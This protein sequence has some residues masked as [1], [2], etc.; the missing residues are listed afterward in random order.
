MR[1]W[2]DGVEANVLQRVGSGQV[3]YELLKN[4][5]NLDQENK[6]SLI[7]GKPENNYTILLSSKPLPDLPKQRLNWKYKILK[8]GRLWTRIAI[9]IYYHLAKI[10]PD[11]ILS[12]THYIPRFIKAKRVP[13]IFDLAFIHFPEMFKKDDLYKLTNWTK[14]SILESAHI[15]TISQSSKKDIIETYKVPEKKVTVSYPGYNDEVFRLIK[16]QDKIEQIREKYKVVGDYIIYIGTVQPRKNLLRLIRSMKKIEDLKLVVV[17]KIRGKG[18]QGWMNEE[19]LEEPK[20][21]EIQEKIIF[22]DYVPPA[23]LPYLITGS[24]AFVLPSL[25]E[26]FGIPVVEA[27]ACG[28][29]VITSNVSSLPEVVSDAG[30]LVNPKSET[31]IEQAIRLLTTDKKLH[32][33]LS[34]K[35]LEQSKKFSWQKM[36]R[37]VIKVL[38]SV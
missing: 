13:V 35:A 18:K 36:A 14:T 4:I 29:P 9:P 30:L 20:K 7:S 12:P 11:V 37:E 34:R 1:I 3:A 17:G 6:Q 21:L 25:W 15:I 38:E 24:K 22:T 19:I 27:M 28:V 16:D 31:Q 26:G 23:E 5:H 32:A 10:K 8:P 2:I 33:R